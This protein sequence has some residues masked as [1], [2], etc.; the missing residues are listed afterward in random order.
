MDSLTQIVLGASVA[1]ATLGKKIGNKAIVLGAIAGTI[2][3]LDIVTRFFVDDLT[4]SVMHRG[5]S[6]SLIFPFVA[7]L[8]LAWILKKIYS[9]YT[10]VSFYDWFKM[11]F[12]AIIT[13]PL[14]DA[15]TTWGTQLFW[16]FEWRVA[17][18]NIFIIDPIYTLPFLTFLIL[19]AFQDRLSK[20][21]RLF[22][23]L[24][25]IISSAYLLVTLSFKGV[26][27]YNIAKGLEENNIEYKD[28]NTRATYF[29]SILWS[30]QI[31]LEDS[32]IFTYYSLF[33]KSK[34]IF[35]KKFPKNHNM[36]QPFIDE[37]KIQQLIILSNGH[38]LM[39]NENDELIFWNLKLGLKGFDENASPYIWSYVIKNNNGEI[40]F[41][42]KNEKMDAL[43]IQERRSFRNNRN[44][45]K[46]FSA[47][48]E[49]LKGI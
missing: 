39:T 46:E 18:E 12:L 29:N 4:A 16:P 36:L 2:P 37:K 38:Y 21:R 17:I 14:L 5:F 20:K 32:Y 25:L 41:D 11:F 42:E 48:Y 26:A 7:A 13:H 15:Q 22:N 3:D 43:K 23:S 47:F 33:D 19:T 49:R 44:Y 31:E 30:S 35:T 9:S 10:H 24:G 40:F 1:E 28:I 34:P 8:I 6:H 45:S 27:H